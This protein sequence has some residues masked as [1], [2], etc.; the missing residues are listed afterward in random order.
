MEQVAIKA[1]KKGFST[2][3]IA[4]ITGLSIDAIKGLI[5]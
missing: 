3:D 5:M 1:Y 4:D 2:E